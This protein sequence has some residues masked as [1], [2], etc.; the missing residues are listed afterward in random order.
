MENPLEP[1]PFE[2]DMKRIAET[3]PSK[4]AFA[5]NPEAQK[6][7]IRAAIKAEALRTETSPSTPTP[8]AS[9]D[10]STLLDDALPS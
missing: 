3:L 5:S 4:E 6:E 10:S 9:G 1:N 8:A 2:R 7:A